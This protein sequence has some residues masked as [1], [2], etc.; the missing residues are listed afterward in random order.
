MTGYAGLVPRLLKVVPIATIIALSASCRNQ[1]PRI[2]TQIVVSP[3]VSSVEV[4]QTQTFS[5]KILDD[6]GGVL[7]DTV[8]WTTSDT[9]KAVIDDHGIVKGVAPGE[10]RVEA[11]FQ[12]LTGAAILNVTDST[13]PTVSIAQPTAGST[14]SGTVTVRADAADNYEVA[15]V[16]LGVDGVPQDTLR[17]GPWD[18]QW[19]TTGVSNGSHSLRVTATDAS[20]NVA[21]SAAVGVTVANPV[22]EALTPLPYAVRAAAVATDGKNVYVVGGTGATGRMGVFQILDLA[23]DQWHLGP[24]LPSGT[25]WATAA[26]VNGSLHL[27]GG[28]TDALGITDQHLVYTPGDTTWR[29]AARAPHKIAGTASV[30]AGSRIYVFAGNI[31]QPQ[32]YSKATLIYD[33]TNDTWTSGADVPSPRINWAGAALNNKV[34]LVGGGTPGL[35]T[36]ADL[37]IYSLDTGSW[38]AGPPIPIAREA[39]GVGVLGGKVCA[40]GGRRAASGNFNT[41]FDD[42]LCFDVTTQEWLPGPPLPR[43]VQEVNVVTLTNAIVAV[44]GADANGQPVNDVSILRS[45]SAAPV[46]SH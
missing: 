5:A 33:A 11:R 24:S 6:H 14:L 19:S 23:T 1:A 17:Q 18:F 13:P 29:Q 9:D 37:L 26:W 31:G 15:S 2:P 45:G 16:V 39:H 46:Q 20:G 40:V 4:G 35:N 44:G 41:P 3:S 30:A 12:D 25:D 7:P 43:A 21:T 27:I 34:Y 38:Q 36:S 28:A 8:I 22:W 32:V 42:V 10:V